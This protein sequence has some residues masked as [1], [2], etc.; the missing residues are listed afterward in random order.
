MN[1]SDLNKVISDIIVDFYSTFDLTPVDIK[2]SIV[3]DMEKA[4]VELRPAYAAAHPKAIAT[5]NMYNG[6]TVMPETLDGAFDVLLNANKMLEYLKEGNL[7][8]IGTIV[9]ETA[10]AVD[11]S[12]YANLTWADSY[13]E[14]QDTAKHAMFQLWTEFNARSKGYYFVRKYTFSNP[15][16][17]RQVK[18]II[19]QELPAQH[20]LLF[21]N[22]HA[23]SNGYQQAYFVAQYLGR[24][25]TL[26]QLFPK[27]FTNG[28]IKSHLGANR[29]MYEWYLF[30]SKYN[31]LA[32]AYDHFEEMKSILRKNFRGL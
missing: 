15:F 13:E 32:D 3:D 4:Y 19:A 25:H 1:N 16:D 12:E 5:A 14:L 22:Y 8:W 2:Y 31:R 17:E 7:T 26:Q 27:H 30:M 11:Y 9:H 10:H 6:L 23:T 18:D 21:Q 29:W 28:F 20:E 24:L